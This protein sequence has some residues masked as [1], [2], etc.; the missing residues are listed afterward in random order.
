MIGLPRST[1]YRR[2]RVVAADAVDPD[3]AL[4]DAIADVQRAYPGYGYRRVTREL[5]R[6]HQPV[7]HKRVQRVMQ[8]M[9]LPP[10]S[11][12]RPWLVAEPDAVTGS[13]YPNRRAGMVP[14]GP[15]QL[16]VADLTYVRLERGFVFLA[17]VLD[18]FAR[19]V[20]GYAI[21]P[22]L[23]ARLPLAALEAALEARQPPSGCVH[24]SD[25]GSQYASRRYRERLA[26]AGLLGS[27]SRAGN[28]YDNAHAESFM[29]TLKH[30]EIYP[31]Q[32]RTM[33]DVIAH[34]PHFLETIYNNNRLHSALGYRSPNEFEADH[35]L[36]LSSGQIADP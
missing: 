17:V 4:R 24:H 16:W 27:M 21:G 25:R 9:L 23:D 10:A 31:R 18:V 1:Y 34:L 20:V 33:A 22:T 12:R 30:E 35:A 26:E 5:R 2:P 28:P 7:N 13:W 3:A 11:R 14:T 36:I 32:Y 8:A 15:D 19:K 6:R 29:K